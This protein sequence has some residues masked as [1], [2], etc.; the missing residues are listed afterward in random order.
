MGGTPSGSHET[1]TEL[2]KEQTTLVD[3]RDVTKSS[4]DIYNAP[5]TKR[6]TMKIL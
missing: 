3:A 6:L 1:E 2:Y 5:N 4:T